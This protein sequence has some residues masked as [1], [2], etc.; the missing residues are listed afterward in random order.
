[1]NIPTRD[2]R[3]KHAKHHC[4]LWNAGKKEEWIASWRS[5]VKTDNVVMYDPVGTEAKKGFDHFTSHAWDLFQSLLKMYLFKVHVNG[6]EMAWV[7]ECHFGEGD[8]VV[9]THSIETFQWC[10]DGSF[11]IKTYY[12]MPEALGEKDDPYQYLLDQNG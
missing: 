10:D 2:E 7:I 11:Q 1:M 8:N 9:V 5:I 6:N 12:E 3:L 4:E